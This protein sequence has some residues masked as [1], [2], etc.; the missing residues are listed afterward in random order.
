MSTNDFSTY[1]EKVHENFPQIP[2]VE[3]AK[4]WCEQQG[5]PFSET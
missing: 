3:I 1:A 4:L 2:V 5:R